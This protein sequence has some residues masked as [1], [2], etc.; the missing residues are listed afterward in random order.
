MRIIKNQTTQVTILALTLVFTFI[1]CGAVYGAESPDNQTNLT[2]TASMD[3]AQNQS[4]TV[5]DPIISGNVVDCQNQTPFAGVTITVNSLNGTELAS[6]LTNENGSYSVAFLSSEKVFNV[7]A[8]YPGHVTST[9]QVNVTPSDPS[10]PNLYGIANFQMGTL[11]L[12]KGS[13]DTIGLDSNNVNTGPDHFMVQIHVTNNAAV[14]AQNV[15]ATFAFTSPNANII[16]DPNESAVKNLGDIAP[17]A[18]VDV[19]YLVNVNRTSAAYNTGRNY[20]ISVAGTNTGSPVD[21]ISGTLFVEKLISQNR[22][23]VTSIVVS[24]SN[25]TLGSNFAVTV[26]STT[27]SATLNPVDLSLIA[28]DPSKIQ[29]VSVTITYSASSTNSILINNPGAT[30][31]VSTWIFTAIGAG[32]TPLSALI[33]DQSGNSYHYNTDFNSTHIDLNVTP[34]ADLGITKTVNNTTP[35]VGQQVTFTITATNYG[36]ND[37]HLVIAN[38]LLPAGLTFVSYTSSPGTTYN[39]GTGVWTIGNLTVGSSVTLNITATVNSAGQIIN[40]VN[41]TGNE[42]DPNPNNNRDTVALNSEPVADLV[43]SKT[44]NNPTPYVGD[45]VTFTITLTNNGPNDAENVT[46]TDILS[47]GLILVSATPSVGSFNPVTGVWSIGTL[48]HGGIATMTIVATVNQTGLLYNNATAT[49]TTFDPTTPNNATATVNAQPSADLGVVK[50]VD[51]TS[52]N[53]GDNVTFTLTVTNYGPSNAT[54]VTANDLLP[55]GL[56]W[57][58]DTSGGAYNHN[59]GIWTIGNLNSGSSV[60]INITATVTADGRINNIVTVNGTEHDPNPLNNQDDVVLNGQPSADMAVTKTVDNPTPNVGDLVTFT[61]TVFNAGPND[62]TGVVSHDLLPTG[63][64]YISSNP[65]VGNYDPVTGLWTIGSLL[66]GTSAVMT[67][68]AQ[69]NQT[70]FLTNIVNVTA[71]Q[72]DPHPEDNTAA[73]TVNAQPTADLAVVKTVTNTTPNVGQ[74]VTFTMVVTNNGPNNATGVIMNDA[75]SAGLN[76]LSAT[77]SQG[78]FIG[79]IWNIGDLNNGSSVTLT[80]V[81]NVTQTGTLNNSVTVTGNQYDPNLS[82]NQDLVILNGQPSADLQ[83]QKTVSNSNPHVGEQISFTVTVFNAGPNDATNTNLTDLLPAGLELVSATPSVGTYTAGTGLWAI[84]TLLHETSAT[85]I[86]VANV[87][88]PGIITN[89]ANAT[90]SVF[91]PHPG[92]NNASVTITANP[93]ADLAVI[94]TVD[95]SNP[96]LGDIIVFTI[97]ATNNGPQNATGVMVEDLL[98]TGLV[99]LSATT[100]TGSYDPG[101]GVW[102]IGNLSAGALP[103][104]LTINAQVNRT[105]TTFSN[106]ATITGNQ[107]DPDLTNNQD[108]VILNS[109]LAADIGVSKTVNNPTPYN[110]DQITYTIS[111]TNA[112]PDTATN[113]IVDDL[114]PEGIVFVNALASQGTYDPIT[115]IWNVGT[116]VNGTGATLTINATVNKTGTINNTATATANQFDPHPGDNTDSVI[117]NVLPSADLSITKTPGISTAP[118]GQQITFTITVTNHGP[119]NASNVVVNDLLPN[120][121]QWLSDTGGGA[122][123]HTTGI[124]TIGSLAN[125]TNATLNITVNVTVSGQQL[126]NMVNVTSTTH[127]PNPTNNQDT[128]IVNGQPTAE[129]SIAKSV[130]T[131]NAYVGEIVNFTITVTNNGPSDATGVIVD[132]YW[133]TGLNLLSTSDPTHFSLIG[134]NIYRWTIGNLAHDAS[135]ILTIVANVTQVGTWINHVNVTG[136]EFDPTIPDEANATVTAE[137]SADLA[138]TKTVSDPTPNLGDKVTFTIV[139]RNDGPNDATGVVLNDL[140]PAG[141]TIAD[142]PT[143]TQGSYDANTGIWTIGSLANG[144]SATLSINAT[145]NLVSQTIT[146]IANIT[147]NEFDPNLSNNQA[148]ATLNGNPA[149]DLAIS[150][151]VNNNAPYVGNQV[152]FT[153][154]VTNAGPDDATGVVVNDLLPAGLVYDHS[155]ASVGNYNETSGEWIIGDL[156]H[157]GSATLTITANVTQEGSFNNVATVSG[158]QYDPHHEDNTSSVGINAQPAANVVIRK[159]VSNNTPNYLDN[160]TYT[161]TVHNNGPSTATGVIIYDPLPAGL[162]LLS[163]PVTSQGTYNSVAQQWNVGTLGNTQDA[164]IQFLVKVIQTGQITNL[165][166]ITHQDQFNPDTTN[167]SA[168]Q[169]INVPPAADLSITK[170]VSNPQPYIHE[171]ITFTLIVQN[172]G[173]DTATGVYVVDQLPAGVTYVSS[174]ANYGSY[175]PNTGIWTIGDLP[176]GA[177]AQLDIKVAVEKYG[178]LENHAHVYSN[179]YDPII[180]NQNA[181]ATLNVLAAPVVTEV[182]AKTIGMQKTGAPLGILVLALLMVLSGVVFGRKGNL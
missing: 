109:N 154:Q 10:D 131:P 165:A 167:S 29:P 79:G 145:V 155:S 94:K 133:P 40:T 148:I 41:I 152:I 68:V 34:E 127:D 157:N 105:N 67:L 142:T 151:T 116:L 166:T 102:N 107:F 63:L 81:A 129:L 93:A 130:D 52:P 176:N 180:D 70:G 7:S 132:D 62:A 80:I 179:T 32:P 169:T 119:D 30:S 182:S 21:T 178:A 77:P 9:Q 83:V 42:T 96:N 168:N 13:W 12:T 1:L 138:V 123:D 115:G 149:A 43:I 27:S 5:S 88:Q 57:V 47:P 141:L 44:V 36:P 99:F 89:F 122:Y 72:F 78:T 146:N 175:N 49:T 103:V 86:L 100:A 19:F 144:L 25:P 153:I 59:T 160:I 113:V 91:D 61:I 120:G 139:A 26:I 147:G 118:I 8:S 117:V 45:Q 87:T 172:H 37:A 110:G 174:S 135:A 124:W 114:L 163:A 18:T 28:Y 97:T 137:A 58:S 24:P 125:G 140:I 126:T 4:Q 51:N 20:T 150:K 31:F 6:T 159:D 108:I 95:N 156:L 85:L 101:S 181:T 35:L 2:D 136:N 74:T 15:V 92:D 54:N 98:P 161:I 158:D 46:V 71:N 73:V 128:A 65:S 173:P 164:T 104:T 82:N 143:T 69:V 106:V 14:T 170:T 177:V 16:L 38:D 55:A 111:V 60:S 75:L 50:T 17:G 134:A 84:G 90:S 121:L 56:N 64:L 112:G 53:V 39:S 171:V 23:S 48:F 22:N 162:E 76:I 33:L 66:H 3:V 11:T